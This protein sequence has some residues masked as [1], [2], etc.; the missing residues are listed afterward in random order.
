MAP[1]DRFTGHDT[2]RRVR[3][4]L[5]A[6]ALAAC[7]DDRA[8]AARPSEPEVTPASEPEP[9]PRD[10]AFDF[11][12][13]RF[14]R[15]E[16]LAHELACDVHYVD[17][18]APIPPPEPDEE[19]RYPSEAVAR[20]SVHCVSD[21]G[22]A[23]IDLAL[24]DE[25][26]SHASSIASGSRIV[27]KLISADGGFSD[28]AL[29]SFVR[30][31]GAARTSFVERAPGADGFDFGSLLGARAELGRSHPCAIDFASQLGAVGDRERRREDYEPS[32]AYRMD[33]RCL[34]ARGDSWVDLLFEAQD[35]PRSLEV[36][37]GAR[38]DFL[39]LTAEDGFADRPI[40]V[41]ESR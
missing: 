20:T 21:R 14:E 34:H 8:P 26:R 2:V 22:E 27:V 33:V 12:R 32:V 25:A 24:D 7:G 31:D 29:A 6:I 15:S 28:Y 37:R 11:R 38:L 16:H 41:F 10:D 36:V 5:F 9:A 1:R 4:A 13:V 19:S 18:L 23:W 17:P 40:V 30:T 39:A 3:I 35:A